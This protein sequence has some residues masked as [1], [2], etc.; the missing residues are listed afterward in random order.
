MSSISLALFAGFRLVGRCLGLLHEENDRISASGLE[1]HLASFAGRF[2]FLAG[3]GAD[4]VVARRR[5]RG[6]DHNWGYR[7]GTGRCHVFP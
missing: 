2:C 1:F 4:C 3:Q 5:L 6:L 7:F